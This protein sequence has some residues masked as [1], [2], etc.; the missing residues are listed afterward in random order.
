MTAKKKKKLRNNEYYSTQDLYDDLYKRSKKGEKFTD[1]LSIIQSKENIK[2][3]YR[4]LKNNKGSKTKGVNKTTIENISNEKTDNMVTYVQNRL[5]N[6]TPHKV[7]RVEIPKPNG[8]LRPLGIPTMEDRLIQQCVKQVLEPICEAKFYNHSYG[9]RPNRSTH[10]AI[11]NAYHRINQN[12]MHYVVDIDIKGFFDNVNH[13]KLIKQMW[14]LGIRDK[15]L[16]KIISKMLKAEIKGIGIPTKGTPQGGILSPLLSNIVLNELDWWIASQWEYMKT[17]HK[18][19]ELRKYDNRQKL[20][21]L[22]ERSNLKE[23]FIVRYADDFKI[24]CKDPKT[25][26]KIFIATKNWLKERLDLEISS[27]KSKITNLRK[28][29]SEFLGIKIKAIKKANKYVVK[30]KLTQ[31]S[32]ESVKQSIRKALIEIK[33][34][35]TQATI[36]KLNSVILGLHNYYKVASHVSQ[37]FHDI[38]W[39][40]LNYTF[41]C[42]SIQ[43]H[44]K[45][46]TPKN[47]TFNKFYN[48][49]KSKTY[50]IGTVSMFPPFFVKTK[51]PMNFNRDINNFTKEGRM[52]IHNN[53]KEIDIRIL[54]K[55][56]ENPIIGQSVQLNDNRIS[57]YVAQKGMCA[58]SKTKLYL[59]NMEVHH[60]KPKELNGTDEYNNLIIITYEIH[61]LIHAKTD[62]TIQKYMEIIKPNKKLLKDINKYRKLAGNN[63]LN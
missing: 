41:M 51:P 25:A 44:L 23:I 26:Q 36:T 17:R 58:L 57:L 12:K 27:E 46:N 52:L 54:K 18:Y 21:A 9:F 19:A 40:G 1:L 60:K 15:N 45:E 20:R 49:Y 6:Y 4:N 50:G 38:W 35:P 16:I 34:N 29:Y 10:H 32:K 62:K 3:A 47:Q 39:N 43:K 48:G 7:R 13:S 28:N 55:L 22:Q 8:K 5:K 59:N 63:V 2:L 31:K 11:A 61:K 14:S 53:L 33:K 42:R 30:S 24:F 37:D 56:M